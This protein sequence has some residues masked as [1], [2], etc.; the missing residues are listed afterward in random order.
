MA[1]QAFQSNSGSSPRDGDLAASTV[2]YQQHQAIAPIRTMHIVDAQAAGVDDSPFLGLMESAN[3]AGDGVGTHSGSRS[4]PTL[5]LSHI[6]HALSAG[7]DKSRAEVVKASAGKYQY[8]EAISRETERSF[9]EQLT[10]SFSSPV[11]SRE[12]AQGMPPSLAATH[13]ALYQSTPSTAEK[14]RSTS[15]SMPSGK[16]TS[17]SSQSPQSS[18]SNIASPAAGV[19]WRLYADPM[20][21]TSSDPQYWGAN[22]TILKVDASTENGNVISPTW[23]VGLPFGSMTEMA[24]AYPEHDK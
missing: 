6:Q 15:T 20:Y 4:H 17:L 16:R 13:P 23:M 3:T 2:N 5:R 9:N 21:Q 11:K 19:P 7:H 22:R 18:S 1:Y 24:E 10:R 12:V 8:H 14:Q